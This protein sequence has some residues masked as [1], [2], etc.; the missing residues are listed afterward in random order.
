D[1]DGRPGEQQAC[2][3][4]GAAFR[5]AAVEWLYVCVEC[6]SK[7]RR[8]GTGERIGKA[9]LTE[10]CKRAGRCAAAGVALS[11]ADA[12]PDVPQCLVRLR[13]GVQRC[14][15]GSRNFISNERG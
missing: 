3:N 15:V 8:T 5:W 4:A 11:V 13:A 10:G 2:G 7:R 14:A 6:G 12:V 1:D 9:I